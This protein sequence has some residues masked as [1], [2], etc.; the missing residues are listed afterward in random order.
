VTRQGLHARIAFEKRQ[1][2]VMCDFGVEARKIVRR[3]P[4][5]KTTA[6]DFHDARSAVFQDVIVKQNEAH[7]LFSLSL[8]SAKSWMAKEFFTAFKISGPFVRLR[9]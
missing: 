9:S 4:V 8:G 5:Q 1:Q 2:I 7:E 3:K 6:Q